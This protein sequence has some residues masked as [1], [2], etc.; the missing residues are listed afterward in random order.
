ME[1]GHNCQ[2]VSR[3]NREVILPRLDNLEAELRDLRAATWPVCQ[4]LKD[5]SM[6]F[7]NLPE[8]RNFLRFLDP[9]EIRNLLRFKAKYAKIDDVSV[10]QEY[11]MIMDLKQ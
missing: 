2:D 8:K 6:P 7:K 9:S 3:L 10:D 11:R 4:S 5:R 1:F